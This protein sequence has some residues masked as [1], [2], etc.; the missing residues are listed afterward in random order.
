MCVVYIAEI[1]WISDEEITDRNCSRGIRFDFHGK[2]NK[3]TQ[4]QQREEIAKPA[5][6]APKTALSFII[7]R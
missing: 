2:T 7:S 6:N 5:N 1:P 4:C 3:L